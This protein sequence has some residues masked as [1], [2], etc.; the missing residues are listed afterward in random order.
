MGQLLKEIKATALG[1]S[2]AIAVG[3]AQKA[4]GS[5]IMVSMVITVVTTFRYAQTDVPIA[6]LETWTLEMHNSI[7][8]LQAMHVTKV[9][10]SMS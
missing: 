5:K 6:E 10:R 1:P 3:I 9:S 4:P 7:K 2:L 8:R